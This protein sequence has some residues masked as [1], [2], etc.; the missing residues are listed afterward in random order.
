M[1][2]PEILNIL[3]TMLLIVSIES[4]L[5]FDNIAVLS[6]IVNKNLPQHQRV[7]ALRYGMI[8][9]FVF[10]GLCLFFVSWILNNPEFGVWFKIAGGLYLIRLGYKGLT[11]AK[12]ST[13]EGEVGWADRLLKKIGMGAFWSTVL[14]VE[15]VDIVFSLDNLAAVVSLSDNFW[16]VVIGVCL[17]IVTM[18]FIATKFIKLMEKYP[19]LEKS[20][21]IVILLLGFKLLTGGL[22]EHFVVLSAVRHIMESHAFDLSFS[23]VM[24]LI[25]F[26]PLLKK[27]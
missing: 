4:I 14:V 3:L 25:F 26:L 23:A 21:M 20:A 11:P 13:E 27:K 12:D 7:Q 16:L 15:M 22:S 8:G 5:S 2:L 18:R 9:A 1:N 6:L 19:S 17:G 10:R 24:M